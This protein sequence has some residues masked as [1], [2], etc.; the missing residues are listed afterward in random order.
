MKLIVIH[1]VPQ[2]MKNFLSPLFFKQEKNLNVLY[3]S[4]NKQQA[5]RFDVCVCGVYHRESPTHSGWSAALG[6]N[7][8]RWTVI[9]CFTPFHPFHPS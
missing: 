3:M 7:D 5:W 6:L 4:V 8:V 1:P 2:N 9:M